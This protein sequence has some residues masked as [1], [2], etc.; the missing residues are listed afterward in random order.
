MPAGA[1]SSLG[2]VLSFLFW[3]AHLRS[4]AG[5]PD[6][7]VKSNREAEMFE[8]LRER[9]DRVEEKVRQIRGYL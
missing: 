7:E 8:E 1:T 3:W 9:I 5:V 6:A 4:R 2:C